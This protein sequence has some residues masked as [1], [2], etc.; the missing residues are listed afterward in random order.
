MLKYIGRYGNEKRTKEQKIE[1][2]GKHLNEH[3]SVRVLEKEYNADGSMIC[4]WLRDYGNI[5]L[6]SLVGLHQL[7]ILYVR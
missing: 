2:I 4:H 1:I 3:I 7:L 6:D 5:F